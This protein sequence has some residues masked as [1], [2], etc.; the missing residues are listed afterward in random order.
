MKK[1]MTLLMALTMCASIPTV[2]ASPVV[3]S[4]V[5]IIV[6]SD[7]TTRTIIED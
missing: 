5:Q 4:R 7:Y 3:P 1:I 2:A 6:Y